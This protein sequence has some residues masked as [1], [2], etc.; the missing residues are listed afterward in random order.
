[1]GGQD[2]FH[3]SVKMEFDLVF[4]FNQQVIANKRL[5]AQSYAAE[6]PLARQQSITQLLG[7]LPQY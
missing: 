4:L 2:Q 3:H 6:M 1:M 5:S 7:Q